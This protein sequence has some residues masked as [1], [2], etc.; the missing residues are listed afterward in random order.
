MGVGWGQDLFMELCEVKGQ[1]SKD[2]AFI[3][4]FIFL[5]LLLC[6]QTSAVVAPV[7]VVNTSSCF[8]QREARHPCRLGWMMEFVLER[9]VVSP[10]VQE[11]PD[12]LRWMIHAHL[13]CL[14][15]CQRLVGSSPPPPVGCRRVWATTPFTVCLQ[16]STHF[17]PPCPKTELKMF[18][19]VCVSV[20][21]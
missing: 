8:I 10:G 9:L 1:A 5:F 19:A 3:F 15:C 6:W 11:G 18:L 17:Y 2:S 21:M 13:W 4:Y 14:C 20:C 7:L 12:D 16:S